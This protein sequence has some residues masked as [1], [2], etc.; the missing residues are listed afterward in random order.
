MHS[1][2]PPITPDGILEGIRWRA[3]VLGTLV[4]IGLTLVAGIA[5]ILWFAGA[6]AFSLD[7]EAANQTTHAALASP[8]FLFCSFLI[9]LAAT[10]YGGY[11]AARRAGVFH[12]RHGGWVAVVSAAV[13][14]VGLLL[15]SPAPG[16]QPPPWY[17]SLALVCM[18]PAGLLGG[19]IAL[20]RG[21]PAA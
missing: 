18:L 4:D 3:V 17:D 14:L 7:D 13:G 9:G 20:R 12:V 5:L 8:E 1:A 10:V 6:D 16:S 19:F 15:S 21:E 11:F 2:P